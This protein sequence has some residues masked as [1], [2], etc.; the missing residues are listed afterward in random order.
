MKKNLIIACLVLLCLAT[1]VGCTVPSTDPT[2][3]QTPNP[4]SST[5]VATTTE[6]TPTTGTTPTSL[7]TPTPS[8]NPNAVTFAVEDIFPGLTFSQPLL[9]TTSGDMSSD[10]FVVEQPGRILVIDSDAAEPEAQVFLDIR[11]LITSSGGEQGLLGLAFH[12]EYAENGL[13]YVNYTDRTGTVIA[14]YRRQTENLR[15]AD[16]A[17]GQILLQFDQP[18][19]NHN[20]G[21]LAFGPDGYLYI[22]SGDGGSSG[23]PQNYAQTLDNL[24]GKILRIDIDRADQ[25][26][27]YAIPTDNPFA[28]GDEGMMPEIYAYGLRNPWRFSFDSSGTLWAADVGQNRI[29]EINHVESGGNYGWNILEG[30]LEYRADSTTDRDSLILPVW[31]YDHSQGR[32][33]TGGYVYEGQ[34]IPSLRGAYVYG[35]FISSRIWALWIDDN[36]VVHNVL[37]LETDLRIASFGV[38]G[39]GEILIADLRGKIYRL[40]ESADR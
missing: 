31:E 4:T 21:H 9:V 14:R 29:E 26:L 28:S 24:L 34:M 32:S 19:G 6:S 22:A 12:P 39:E 33:V 5:P 25:G 37:I 8:P 13:F 40:I 11:N 20:G 30:T 35:D 15:T 3:T 38:D 27:E 16:P 36:R 1:T 18:Y 2:S 10:L 17:S 23:D 7:P